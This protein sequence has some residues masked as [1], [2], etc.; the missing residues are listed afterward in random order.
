MR[1]VLWV[2]FLSA[3]V[4]GL[5]YW[6]GDYIEF[7]E[8]NT[9]VGYKGLA[10]KNH[11]LAA[12]YFLKAM[13]QDAKRID[14]YSHNIDL[15]NANDTLVMTG[16]RDSMGNEKSMELIKWIDTGGHLI[17]TARSYLE[18]DNLAHD[19]LLDDF[20]ISGNHVFLDEHQFDDIPINVSINDNA[21]F[22]LVGFK[23][24]YTLQISD[25]KKLDILWSVEDDSGMH[26]VSIS[27]GEGKLIVLSDMSMFHNSEIAKYDN[28]A[29]IWGL[30]NDKKYTGNVYYSLFETRETIFKWIYSNAPLFL[31]TLLFA[32]VIFIWTVAPR[33]GPIINIESPHRRSFKQHVLAIGIYYWRKKDYPVLVEFSQKSILRILYSR[34]PDPGMQNRQQLVST[35]Q[36]IITDKNID[37]YNTLYEQDTPTQES[38]LNKIK[39]LEII[40][41]AI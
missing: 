4:A 37:I 9:E 23:K 15:L 29:F 24:Y 19:Y 1:I 8:Q 39:S 18:D 6:L 14:I 16:Y 27:H 13:G 40:R 20:G 22:L 41:K 36:N 10:S 5:I 21:E 26:A 32:M 31:L 25:T 34:Y 3:I 11:L 38:F 2:I 33:F 7:Y 12:E 35:L 30:I 28:A 17:V